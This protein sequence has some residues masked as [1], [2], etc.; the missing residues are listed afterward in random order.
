VDGLHTGRKSEGKGVSTCLGDDFKR[1][2]EFLCKFLGR[3]SGPDIVGFDKY[4][5]SHLEVQSQSTALGS[6]DGVT[7][8]GRGDGLSEILMELIEV[9]HKFPCLGGSK[10]SFRMYGDVRVVTLVGKEWGNA[11][12]GI[13]SIIICEFC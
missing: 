8:L 10:V 6:G 12:G 3:P 1:S 11:S 2:K 7:E 4:L 9:H 13:R 5:V